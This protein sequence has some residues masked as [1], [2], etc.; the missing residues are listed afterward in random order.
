MTTEAKREARTAAALSPAMLPPIT[1]AFAR[2]GSGVKLVIGILL[3]G[4]VLGQ[5]RPS[6][7][8]APCRPLAAV[9]SIGMNLSDEQ[10]ALLDAQPAA[11]M[12]T[13]TPDGVAKAVRVGVGVIDGRVLSSGT[14]GRVRTS[15]LRRD[16]RC[17]L[18]VQ[19]PGYGYLVLETIVTI[20]DGS[21]VAARTLR[22]MRHFQNRPEGPVSWFGTNLTEEEFVQT[23]VK[24]RRILYDF[25]V[26]RAYG[27]T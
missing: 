15:R 20:D 13:V 21:D 4:S 27:T 2:E 5:R 25:E 6:P 7:L 9:G 10:R 19:D 1:T 14:E 26:L 17:T 16:P 12:I 18:Y 8:P 3:L 11:A 24:E 23:M 22:L